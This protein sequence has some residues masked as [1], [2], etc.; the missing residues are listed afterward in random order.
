[1]LMP[2]PKEAAFELQFLSLRIT[3]LNVMRSDVSRGQ[4]TFSVKRQMVESC[5]LQGLCREYSAQLQLR[6][7]LEQYGNEWASPCPN[8]TVLQVAGLWA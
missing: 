1:M 4:P 2:R 7:R 3:I 8:K 5:R 6:S